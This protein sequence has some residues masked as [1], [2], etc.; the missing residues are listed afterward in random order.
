MNKKLNLSYENVP[1]NVPNSLM[2]SGFTINN[3]EYIDLNE[4]SKLTK[5]S[6]RTT[7]RLVN[8]IT[9]NPELNNKRYI[10]KIGFPYKIFINKVFVDKQVIKSLNKSKFGINQIDSC[11][12]ETNIDISDMLDEKPFTEQYIQNYIENK[13]KSRTPTPSKIILEDQEYFSEK[14]KKFTL[15]FNQ[16]HFNTFSNFHVELNY[17]IDKLETLIRKFLLKLK[18]KTDQFLINFKVLYVIEKNKCLTGGYHFHILFSIDNKEKFDVFYSILMKQF[19]KEKGIFNVMNEKYDPS[20]MGLRYCF[21][22]VDYKNFHFGFDDS[23]KL[24]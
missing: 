12:I 20:K 11:D 6:L 4:Y 9:S 7:Q 22:T 5:K 10:F 18:S 17:S 23:R 21:K 3:L 1:E 14:Q 16:F 19:L 13:L 24:E 15:F 2:I 8:K